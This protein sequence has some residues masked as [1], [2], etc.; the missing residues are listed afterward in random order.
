MSEQRGAE[1]LLQVLRRGDS[2]AARALVLN[3]RDR[4]LRYA[5][6]LLSD[7]KE[8]EDAVQ[9]V[10]AALLA[11]REAPAHLRTWLYRC[12]RNACIRR[13]A[14][15]RRTEKSPPS[16]RDARALSGTLKEDVPEVIRAP[17]GPRRPLLRRLILV[18]T[19]WLRLRRGFLRW[20]TNPPARFAEH[21]WNVLQALDP[22]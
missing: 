14:A 6:A 15:S 16:A 2:A 21:F 3:Y 20:A 18:G 17:R 1:D 19:P 10:F 12:T 8:S 11:E 4:R 7:P 9:D 5:T 22:R 13:R